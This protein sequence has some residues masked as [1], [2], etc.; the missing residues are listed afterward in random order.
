[1][2]KY[3]DLIKFAGKQF[4]WT[5]YNTYILTMAPWTKIKSIYENQ[6]SNWRHFPKLNNKIKMKLQCINLVLKRHIFSQRWKERQREWHH[7]YHS[8]VEASKHSTLKMVVTPLKPPIAN[9]I[10]SITWRKQEGKGVIMI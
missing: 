3:F 9:T 5:F 10:S 6:S 2:H 8:S 1:M 7:P 4:S